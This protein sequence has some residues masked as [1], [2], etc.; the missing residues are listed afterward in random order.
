MPSNAANGTIKIRC[1]SGNECSVP[2]FF[3]YHILPPAY[4]KGSSWAQPDRKFLPSMEGDSNVSALGLLEV[5]TTKE[6]SK[7]EKRQAKVTNSG[8]KK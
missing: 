2:Q 8:S 1:S 6:A 4:L 5:E 7:E 3:P